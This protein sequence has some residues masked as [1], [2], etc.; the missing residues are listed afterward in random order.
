[1]GQ[2]ES[3]DPLNSVYSVD[4]KIEILG[5]AM[6]P[7]VSSE[8]EDLREAV[9]LEDT[10]GFVPLTEEPA[11]GVTKVGKIGAAVG[12]RGWPPP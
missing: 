6:P 12:T 2:L 5:E 3:H 7:E 11:L 8:I 10:S 4:S 9:P 1:M